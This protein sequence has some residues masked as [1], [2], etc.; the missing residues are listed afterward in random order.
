MSEALV[1]KE[2]LEILAPALATA[3]NCCDTCVANMVNEANEKLEQGGIT[4]YRYQMG[5]DSDDYPEVT[6]VNTGETGAENA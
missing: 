6:V 4:E 3:D 1:L 5:Y 2:V